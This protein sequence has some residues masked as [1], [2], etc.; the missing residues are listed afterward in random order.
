M[1]NVALGVMVALNILHRPDWMV[2]PSLYGIVMTLTSFALIVGFDLS[3][4]V[5]P[6]KTGA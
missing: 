2:V 6:Q 5:A 3:N 4:R 1:H